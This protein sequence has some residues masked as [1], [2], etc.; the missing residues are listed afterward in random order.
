[1]AYL[2]ELIIAEVERLLEEGEPFS[3]WDVTQNLREIHPEEVDTVSDCAKFTTKYGEVFYNIEHARVKS[4]VHL[5]LQN[6]NPNKVQKTDNGKFKVYTPVKQV[7][8]TTGTVVVSS[9]LQV[10]PWTP[11]PG[12]L[13]VTPWLPAPTPVDTTPVIHWTNQPTVT[14]KL[15]D[16]DK[17]LVESAWDILKRNGIL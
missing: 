10:T 9:P 17:K 15:T 4:L 7:P 6:Y 12:P 3:A 14:S 13:Q 2:H 11:T 8:A 1:M 16:S 5:Y